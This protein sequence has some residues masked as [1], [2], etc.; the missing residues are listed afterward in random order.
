MTQDEYIK[1]LKRLYELAITQENIDIAL[2]LLDRI[3]ERQSNA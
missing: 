3:R 1:E 2:A